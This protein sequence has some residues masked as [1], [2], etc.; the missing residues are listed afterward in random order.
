MAKQFKNDEKLDSSS[1]VHGTHL[2]NSKLQE[3]IMNIG[4]MV[5]KQWEKI[6]NIK[7][8]SHIQ[9][10]FIYIKLFIGDGSNGFATQNAYIDLIMQLGWT[11]DNGGRA[12]CTAELHPLKSTFTTDNTNIIVISNSNIDYDI[13]FTTSSHYCK[14]NYAVISSNNATVTPA[15]IL[16]SDKPTGTSCN[17]S[18]TSV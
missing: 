14:P 18:Y 16:S 11:G 2:L 12:G 9:G 17:L 8:D 1:V 3:H 4:K 10:E 13:Y 6:C 15:F 5:E 7:L